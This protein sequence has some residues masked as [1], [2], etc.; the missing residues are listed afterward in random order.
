MT[1]PAGDDEIA[2]LGLDGAEHWSRTRALLM[3]WTILLQPPGGVLFAASLGYGALAR[4]AGLDLGLTMFLTGVFFA[5]PAQIVLTDQI[6]RDAALVGAAFAV[7]LTA[8]RLLPMTVSLMPLLRDG[9]RSPRFGFLATHFVA[10]SI[11][12]EGHRRLPVLPPRLRLAHFVGLGLG[13]L[14][15]TLSGAAVGYIIADSLPPLLAAA[16]LLASPNYLLL[17]LL[18]G[19]GDLPDWIAIGV[20]AMLGPL[21]YLLIPGLD[22][23]ISGLIGGTIAFAVASRGS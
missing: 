18:G 2:A 9:E 13:M 22:L 14:S 19:A 8:V 21:L 6:A 16:L 20:G 23:M 17:S 5:L 12:I 3:G 7:T 10:V 4:D 15:G 1:R 11:W